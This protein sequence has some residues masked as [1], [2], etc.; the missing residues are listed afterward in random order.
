MPSTAHAVPIRF[1]DRL[2]RLAR[3]PVAVA[4]VTNVQFADEDYTEGEIGGAVSWERRDGED[5]GHLEGRME[6]G[7]W[8]RMEWMEVRPNQTLGVNLS[9]CL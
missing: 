6:R 9:T 1:I 3:S 8:E 5:Y 4:E 7:G 2:A